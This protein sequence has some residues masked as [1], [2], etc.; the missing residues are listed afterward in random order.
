MINYPEYFDEDITNA[1]IDYKAMRAKIKKP[2][3]D[4]AIKRA[5]NNLGRLMAQG[6]DILLVLNQSEDRC[7]LG[8]FPVSEAYYQELGINRSK[9]KYEKNVFRL[10][11]RSWAE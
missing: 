9:A 1:F 8:L 10:T 2:L 5:F 4:G 3:T 6:E 11:D 7:W